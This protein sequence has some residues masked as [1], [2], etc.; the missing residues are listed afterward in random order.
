MSVSAQK[1]AKT[2]KSSNSLEKNSRKPFFETAET[3]RLVTK[4]DVADRQNSI[5]VED[6][7]LIRCLETST[8]YPR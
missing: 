4:V 2:L 7:D 6:S 3:K 1:T 8:Y 5:T